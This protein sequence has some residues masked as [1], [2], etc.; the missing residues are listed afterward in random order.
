MRSHLYGEQTGPSQAAGGSANGLTAYL[1]GV[2]PF[3]G[4]DFLFRRYLPKMSLLPLGNP[5]Q[6]IW[7][8]I[9]PLP[10]PSPP[11]SRVERVGV[12]GDRTPVCRAPS[13]PSS[14]PYIFSKG[15]LNGRRYVG[16]GASPQRGLA[17]PKKKLYIRKWYNSRKRF[18]SALIPSCLSHK[19]SCPAVWARP[20]L[21]E[22][23]Y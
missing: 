18:L 21:F 5:L 3:H 22:R 14:W 12:K 16:S 19:G 20:S 6:K 17:P 2:I 11:F 15:F 9:P 1:E 7:Y 10:P 8:Y 4:T 23:L 13:V